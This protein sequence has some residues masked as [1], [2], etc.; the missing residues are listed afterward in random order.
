MGFSSEV[1]LDEMV[2]LAHSKGL[3][4]IDDVGA[5]SLI[6][7]SRFGFEPEPTI[8]DSIKKGADIVTSSGDKLIGGPQAGIIAGK[9][10]LIEKI[11]KNQFARIVRADKT[12]LAALEAT[13]R[14]FLDEETALKEIPTIE[15]VLRD[16]SSL[17]KRAK[18]I[19]TR[20]KKANLEAKISTCEGSS[21]MGSGSLPL[22]NLATTLVSVEP[23]KITAEELG[24]RLR[25]YEI[26]VFT[27]IQNEAVLIDPRTLRK[28][29]DKI[30]IKA[31]SEIL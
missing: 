15:M 30:I 27:R 2:E 4:V 6:D 9:A 8:P 13:L 31:L 22:Q 23:D 1:G 14:L 28:S 20:L 3:I 12:T 25:L 24:K 7:F 11:R 5:G 29:D 16:E 19:S 10:E 17:R 21:Q 18:S 26:P